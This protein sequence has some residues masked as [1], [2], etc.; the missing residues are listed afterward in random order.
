MKILLVGS[1]SIHVS[2]FIQAIDVSKH[3]VN[4]LSEE[5]CHFKGVKKEYLVDFR[6][7]SPLN[8]IRNYKKINA[9]IQQ[10]KPDVIHIH[11][12]NRL[13]Y[14]VTKCASKLNI[15]VVTTAWGSDVL[16]MPKKNKFF[17]FLVKKTLQRSNYVTA[18]SQNMIDEMQKISP[19]ENKY[20]LLQYGIDK[21]VSGEKEKIVYS[22]RFHNPLYRIDQIIHY[23]IDFHKSKPE[24]KLVLASTGT[25]TEKLKN[26]IREHKLE[27]EVIFVGWQNREENRSW[28][29]KASIYIS[30]PESDG[31]SA[32]VLEAMSA[33]CIPILSDIPVTHEWITNGVN[34]IIESKNQNP[35]EAALLIDNSKCSEINLELINSKASRNACL[36]VFFNLYQN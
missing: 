35:F 16:L 8:I 24:W 9:I 7:L 32:S 2:S 34:G 5:I 25:E 6:N 3:E 19:S 12:V 15:K 18:D 14:F 20:V 22:N 28:Y 23:F 31:T 11:Q 33:S 26:T 17:H 1:N 4:L 21:I 29:A 10:L 36:K 13:A 30:I 27:Q